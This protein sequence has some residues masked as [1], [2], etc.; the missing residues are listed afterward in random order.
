[1]SL[2]AYVK[3]CNKRDW[4]SECA[5]P[6]QHSCAV[7]AK[8]ISIQNNKSKSLTYEMKSVLN[9]N[10]LM[11]KC[12]TKN[13]KQNSFDPKKIIRYLTSHNELSNPVL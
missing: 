8:Y 11:S 9:S 6:V 2:F 1:M 4:F 7:N 13:D 5:Y 12:Y 3:K 10:I